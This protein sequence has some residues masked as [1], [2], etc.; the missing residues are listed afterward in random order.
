AI[1]PALDAGAGG[2]VIRSAAEHLQPVDIR[3][4]VQQARRAVA[5]PG[6]VVVAD[7]AR[8]PRDV[9]EAFDAGADLVAVDSGF[10]EAGPGLAKR[11][12]EAL[13]AMRTRAA[14]SDGT[15]RPP[16][17]FQA[18]LR[19]GWFWLLLLGLAMLTAGAIVFSVGL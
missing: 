5:S 19:S 13:V 1:Q 16:P 9:V 3:T 8:S 2:L 7:G 12:N 18:A 6:L 11:S 4:A 10:I 14:W 17:S 15:P